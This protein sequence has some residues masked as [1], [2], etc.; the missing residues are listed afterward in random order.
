MRANSCLHDN[1]EAGDTG[2]ITKWSVS[3]KQGK[4]KKKKEGER[5]R[6]RCPMCLSI[7]YSI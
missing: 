7:D 4:R 2:T 6:E 1:C 3:S 5:E